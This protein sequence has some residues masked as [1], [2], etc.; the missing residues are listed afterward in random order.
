MDNTTKIAAATTRAAKLDAAVVANPGLTAEGESLGSYLQGCEELLIDYM[1]GVEPPP[2]LSDYSVEFGLI[3]Y[4][5]D[6]DFDGTAWGLPP[7][8]ITTTEYNAWKTEVEGGPGVVAWDGTLIGDGTWETFDYG[9][10]IAGMDYLLV[11]YGELTQ[12]PF[13]TSPVTISANEN[14]TIALVGDWGT[15]SWTDGST[16]G[17]AMQVIQQM[18]QVNADYNIHL[19][20]VYYVGTEGSW[21]DPSWEKERF[22]ND[23]PFG[24]NNSFALNSNHEQYDASNGYFKTALK[25]FSGQNA[26]SYFAIVGPD[27]PNSSTPSWAVIGLD[28]AYYDTSSMFMAGAID[29]TQQQFL[30]QFQDVPFVVLLTHHNPLSTDG[31]STSLSPLLG[32]VSASNALGRAPEMWYWGHIHN[33]IVYSSKSAIAPTL[34]RCAGHGAIPFGNG[35]ALGQ[36]DTI[37]WYANVPMENPDPQQANRVRNGFATLAFSSGQVV[38]TFYDQYGET[39]WTNTVP[40]PSE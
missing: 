14:T 40:L 1:T 5:L 28:S 21:I 12:P 35:A 32:Q 6:T 3:L 25:A 22:V 8:K 2:S 9:W 18:Q 34:G 29:A 4:W 31:S 7:T 13:G 27:L 24:G 39:P 15:G 33:G 20:D 26:T 19:G 16:S 10:A 36:M 37:A 23:W 38:E 11:K 17:P 30:A